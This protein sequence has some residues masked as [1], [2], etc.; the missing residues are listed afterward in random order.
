MVTMNETAQRWRL[1]LGPQATDLDPL[2]PKQQQQDQA[3]EYLAGR[4]QAQRGV[5]LGHDTQ[6]PGEQF[7]SDGDLFAEL[8]EELAE[9]LGDDGDTNDDGDHPSQPRQAQSRQSGR[10]GSRLTPARWLG[11]VRELFPQSAV[12]ILQQQA[13]ERYG[14]VSL[15]TDAEIMRQTPPSLDLVRT[16][17]QYQ[18]H[19]SGQAKAEARR[20]IRQVV[21]DIEERIRAHLINAVRGP[22]NRH[23]LG[24]R[25]ALANVHWPA[26]VKHNLPHY[27]LELDALVL[28][29]VQFSQ[30]QK[31]S[32]RWDIF[33]VVDQSGSMLDSVI[34]SAV[35]AA[36][37]GGI[38]SLSTHYLVFDTQV[39]D[40]SE[41]LDDPVEILTGLQLGGGTDIAQAMRYCA[42]KINQPQ[43]SI[44]VLISDFYEG[45]DAADLVRQVGA[46][47]QAGVQCLGLAALD[48]RAQPDY[49]RDMAQRLADVGMPVGAMTPEH[50]ADWVGER[51]R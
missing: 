7:G 35:V 39:V 27:N 19:L 44:M 9:S 36:I 40:L 37:F 21:K 20:I 23:R 18:S 33:I 2:S 28:E 26:T 3:L 4:E 10:G 14:L 42:S 13:V 51:V 32:L 11:Q 45:G 17:I 30:R 41:R 48:D 6:Y 31:R 24:G 34:H 5:G 43:R 12:D 22:R 8:L 50:L 15:L 25:P 46:L 47:R 38:S 1:I 49:D 29:K 16:L